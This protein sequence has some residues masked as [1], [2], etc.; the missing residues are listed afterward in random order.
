MSGQ[1]YAGWIAK[2][3][4]ER[5]I[6]SLL[7][8]NQWDAK[9]NR[10]LSEDNPGLEYEDARRAL[11]RSAHLSVT[12]LA[13]LSLRVSPSDNARNYLAISLIAEGKHEQATTVLI[14]ALATPL[15]CSIAIATTKNL[16]LCFG[17]SETY[18]D[19]IDCLQIA[20]QLDPE[21]PEIL[22]N[23]SLNALLCDNSRAFLWAAERLSVLATV[24]DLG[25]DEFEQCHM[26]QS[27][28][29]HLTVRQRHNAR[30]ARFLV[31]RIRHAIAER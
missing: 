15:S 2:C 12:E 10:L 8:I 21:D 9:A 31:K 17:Q 14:K 19:A 23:L 27:L 24:V 25:L 13:G 3:Y 1:E 6:P 28:S 29:R 22:L 18:A 5:R 30:K 16:A 4:S 20:H 11:D 7:S 26:L